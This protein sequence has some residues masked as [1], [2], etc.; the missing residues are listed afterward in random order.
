MDK[1]LVTETPFDSGI[2]QYRTISQYG[3]PI[4]KSLIKSD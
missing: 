2:Y 4:G 3:K 1:D